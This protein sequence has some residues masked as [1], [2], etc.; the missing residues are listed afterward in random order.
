ML[1]TYIQMKKEQS[2]IKLTRYIV[3]RKYST[4]HIVFIKSIIKFTHSLILFYNEMF[5]MYKG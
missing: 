4:Y 1:E 2:I 3:C 5:G